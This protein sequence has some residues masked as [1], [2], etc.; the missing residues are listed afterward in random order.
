MKDK[1]TIGGNSGER[2]NSLLL[3]DDKI[4]VVGY[5][6]SSDIDLPNLKYKKDMSEAFII[7][8]DYDGKVLNKKVYGGLQNDVFSHIILA[9]PDTS[10]K[11]NNTNDYIVVGYSNSR[12]GLFK[13]NGKD[14]YAK[15]LRY[16]SNLELLIEK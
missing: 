9:I 12:H 6:N 10:N 7:E 3:L 14:Y 4:V 16:N 1:I 13:G 15:V 5:T 2:F 11:V 8:Y